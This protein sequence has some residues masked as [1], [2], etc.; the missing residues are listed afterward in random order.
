M[1]GFIRGYTVHHLPVRIL[2]AYLNLTLLFIE[3][4]RGY[5]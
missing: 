5:I 2:S 1:F 3:G 4:I